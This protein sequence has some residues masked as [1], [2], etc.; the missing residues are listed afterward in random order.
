MPAMHRPYPG[1]NAGASL[2]RLDIGGA[3]DGVDLPYPGGNAG[4]SLKR[5]HPAKR[6]RCELLH[7]PAET[8]GPH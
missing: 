7:T 4:A 2:K 5:F 8:P 6:I 3:E 1:G